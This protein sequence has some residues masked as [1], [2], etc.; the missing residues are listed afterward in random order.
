MEN[1][2]NATQEDGLLARQFG[3]SSPSFRLAVE[4]QVGSKIGILG[5]HS[6]VILGRNVPIWASRG[7]YTVHKVVWYQ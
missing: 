5:E 2:Y 6:I 3:L 7:S 4:H 1:A